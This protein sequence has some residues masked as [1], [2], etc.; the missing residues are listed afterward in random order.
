M[1]NFLIYI[2]VL[3]LLMSCGGEEDVS[4]EIELETFEQK[5][6]YTVGV[7]EAKKITGDP[8]FDSYNKDL[9]IAGFK[10]NFSNVEPSDCRDVFKN[11]FGLNNEDF[12]MQ[13]VDEGSRC[14]GRYFAYQSFVSLE[15]VNKASVIDTINFFQ[16]FRDELLADSILIAETDQQE[17]LRQFDESVR[18]IINQKMEDTWGENKKVGV[19]FLTENAKKKGVKVT[20]SG[21]Q[22]E[23]L[24][25]GS[26]S[27]PGL[28]DNVTV[29]YTGYLIDG[30]K[31][32]SSKDGGKPISFGVG[33]VIPG[34]TEV[35]QLM[36]KGAKF[37]V[38]IPQELAYSGNPQ[39]G[40]PIEPFSALVFEIE[41]IEF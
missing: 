18:A 1:K 19:D 33:G 12:N 29:H 21:L 11:L 16:G 39:P 4:A 30:T 24:S 28:E 2:P 17:L 40:G 10:E 27:S 32:E 9:V 5:L 22:Y 35:L 34:W 25:K 13:Y 31:F 20:A 37:K 23:I 6:S 15:S 41:L 38:Y 7:Q 8:N 14:V 36:S 26:G 3:A